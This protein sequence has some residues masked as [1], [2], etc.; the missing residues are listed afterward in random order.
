M[1]Q[2]ILNKVSNFDANKD[3]TF[4]FTYL[5]AERTTTNMISIREDGVD[6]KTAYEREVN[7][8]DRLHGLDKGTLKNGTTYY[9]KVRVK[10]LSGWSDWSPEVKFFC[11]E[12]PNISFD[13]IDSKN[14]VY[15]DDISMSA[16]YRQAQ[17]EPVVNY[18]FT[19][20]DQ[21]HVTIQQYPVRVP[22]EHSPNRFA[23]RVQGLVKGRLYYIACK[24]I[25]KNGIVYT[26]EHQFVPQYIVP[27]I[28]GII[29][30]K[31]V[32]EEGQIVVQALLKQLLATQA[33]PFIPNKTSDSD[34]HYTY[35]K[36]DFVIIPANN[37]LMFTKL[38]MAKAS[39]WSAKV[40]CMNVPNGLFLD[41]APELG[42][43]IH[44][45]FIKYDDYI[46]CEKEYSGLK[47][48]TK[49]NVVEGLKLSNFY[50]YIKVKEFRVEMKI[51]KKKNP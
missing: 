42:E 40:W 5:G 2:P 26:G 31:L 37:P 8:F 48:R 28:D 12:T 23:E 21:R 10:E 47:S 32:E 46:V 33:K 18:Q 30:P 20:Y 7:K 6:G 41:F 17:G 25:T 39:D 13:M 51:V 29:H 9:A 22:A 43:G 24:V 44:V 15:N 3:Y 14:F 45:K 4:H 38:G 35:Y 49:S 27:T 19:L 50:L 11:L 36:D 16:I 34:H 1:V